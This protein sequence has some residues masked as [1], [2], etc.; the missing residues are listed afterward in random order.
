M[1]ALCAGS[2]MERTFPS[3]GDGEETADEE[4][5]GDLGKG[6]FQGEKREELRLEVVQGVLGTG[7]TGG[8]CDE[9]VSSL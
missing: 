3:S 7:G 2:G 1:I 8:W 9:Q 5:W 6:A 4:V